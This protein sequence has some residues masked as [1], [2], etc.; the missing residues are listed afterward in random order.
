[1]CIVHIAWDDK[2]D[3]VSSSRVGLAHCRMA[4]LVLVTVWATLQLKHQL[5]AAAPQHGTAA[6]T[7]QEWT[8]SQISWW[9]AVKLQWRSDEATRQWHGDVASVSGRKLVH[10]D[11]S[12]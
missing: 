1:M 7:W 6:L 2:L 5:Q 10:A 3:D 12:L 11:Y 4:A 8:P 9:A